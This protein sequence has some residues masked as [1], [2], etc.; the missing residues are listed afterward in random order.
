MRFRKE[1]NGLE[2]IIFTIMTK[3]VKMAKFSTILIILKT[4]E[5]LGIVRNVVEIDH[6]FFVRKYDNDVKLPK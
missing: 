6:I 1:G 2:V 3:I 5:T 4:F